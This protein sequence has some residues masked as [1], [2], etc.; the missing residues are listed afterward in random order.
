MVIN[1][2]ILLIKIRIFNR[3]DNSGHLKKKDEAVLA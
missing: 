1:D 3:S 2:R